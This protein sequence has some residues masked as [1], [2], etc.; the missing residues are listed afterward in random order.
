MV[1]R[2]ERSL[3]MISRADLCA[4]KVPM[5]FLQK[6]IDVVD[7]A[8]RRQLSLA[9][10]TPRALP[11]LMGA[12]ASAAANWLQC[13]PMS[14]RPAVSEGSSPHQCSCVSGDLRSSPLVHLPLLSLPAP[15]ISKIM[16]LVYA[17]SYNVLTGHP[18]CHRRHHFP[19]S[20]FNI[21]AP[22]Y[23]HPSSAHDR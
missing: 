14:C 3:E 20:F 17:T 11:C 21:Y 8:Q 13:T 6:S 2:E 15:R 12:P 18:C 16:C 7:L 4:D 23:P 5:C 10:L 22:Q 19:L 9:C 1:L